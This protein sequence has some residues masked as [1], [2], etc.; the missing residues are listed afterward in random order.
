MALENK[1]EAVK[2]V[3]EALKKE[4]HPPMEELERVAPNKEHFQNLL[5]SATTINKQASF[6]KV[7]GSYVA[8]EGVENLEKNPVIAEEKVSVQGN[9]TATDQERKRRQQSN[10]DSEGVEKVGFAKPKVTSSSLMEE[11]GK[12]N[13]QSSKAAH[14]NPEDLKNQA[15][16]IIA[17]IED[18]KTQ[19]SHAQPT[20][21]KSSYHNVLRN[22]LTHIDD[23]LKIALS[24][25][26][27][28]N[29]ASEKVV[30]KGTVNPIERFLGMLTNSQYQLEHLNQAIEQL[31]LTKA[32]LTPADMLA[33]QI[34]VG[35]VGQQI[36]LF[37]SLLNKALEST[38]TIMN[39]QV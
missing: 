6:Q 11:V 5:D 36:E 2:K 31:S 17:Q 28:E 12:L 18:V 26:G 9:G 30:S 4:A 32:E 10:S 8:M 35:F 33:L 34:K 23:S 19:L 13:G 15:H 20:D 29:Q 21:I 7:D 24:K 16:G 14:L 1:V 3:T 37:T 39:V 38:K 27:I 25:A 22:R